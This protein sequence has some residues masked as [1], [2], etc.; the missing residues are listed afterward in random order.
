MRD[1]FSFLNEKIYMDENKRNE[2]KQH[3]QWRDD[4]AQE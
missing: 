1:P 2:G 4:K 3:Q